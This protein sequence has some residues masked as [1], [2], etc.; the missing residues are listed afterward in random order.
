ME[1]A[2]VQNTVEHLSVWWFDTTPKTLFED[3]FYFDYD[4]HDTLM[5]S[6]SK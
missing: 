5:N 2:K 6:E 4:T 3:E 1:N